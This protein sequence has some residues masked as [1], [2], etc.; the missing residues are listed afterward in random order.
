MLRNLPKGA[1]L[2]LTEPVPG[3]VPAAENLCCSLHSRVRELLGFSRDGV[4]SEEG[5]QKLYSQ[6]PALPRPWAR[7]WE[8]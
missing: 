7:R 5:A 2:M 1:Q 6:T 4:C 3:P 8:T